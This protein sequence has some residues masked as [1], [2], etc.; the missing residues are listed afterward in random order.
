MLPANVVADA[1][2]ETYKG[3]SGKTYFA[4][5]AWCG[6]EIS[7][8]DIIRGK[9]DLG[10][11]RCRCMLWISRHGYKHKCKSFIFVQLASI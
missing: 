8:F 3:F 7:V 5:R 11:N 4:M 10:A 9:Y 6:H 2:V 1:M